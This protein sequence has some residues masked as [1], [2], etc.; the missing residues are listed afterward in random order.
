MWYK[1]I[2]SASFSFVT[3]HACDR[4]TDGR[5]DRITTPKTALAYAR[6]VKI[7]SKLFQQS[8][9]VDVRLKLDWRMWPKSVQQSGESPAVP[10]AIS[11][12]D[13][14]RCWQLSFVCTACLALIGK[15]SDCRLKNSW[16]EKKCLYSTTAALH[17]ENIRPSTRGEASCFGVTALSCGAWVGNASPYPQCESGALASENLGD[18]TLKFVYFWPAED[19]QPFQFL[20]STNV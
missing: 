19:K 16:N 2:C 7:V 13:M 11:H 5:T 14:N 20:Y 12:D 4:Q 18:L 8:W 9:I 17:T 1:N 6:A 15:H 3:I 10:I